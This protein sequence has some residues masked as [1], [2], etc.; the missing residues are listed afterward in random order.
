[1]DQRKQG[2]VSMLWRLKWKQLHGEEVRS[3]W[4]IRVDNFGSEAVKGVCDHANG[5]LKTHG[6]G[7]HWGARG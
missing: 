5:C 3:E 2:R 1:M 7:R 4:C 6:G